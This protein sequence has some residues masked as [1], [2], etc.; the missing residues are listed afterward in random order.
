MYKIH[1]GFF[2]SCHMGLAISTNITSL[3]K[4][5]PTV[6]GALCWVL[7]FFFSCSGHDQQIAQLNGYAIVPKPERGEAVAT[8]AGGCFWAMQESLL[9]LKGVRMVLSGYAGGHTENPSYAAVLGKNTGHAE[10]VQV[11]YDPSV[12]SFRQL[13]TAF[14][15]AHDPTQLN[16]QGPDVGSDYRSIA[17]YRNKEELKTI[18]EVIKSIRHSDYPKAAIVTEREPFTVFYPAEMEHQD[19]YKRNTWDPYI[20][21]ISRPKVVHVREKLPGLIKAAYL[22]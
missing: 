5:R 7:L 15:Y 3:P 14:F 17:F 9:Q 13:S 11:Y 8:F 6:I 12:L 4:K 22:K 18:G 1:G 16:R 21:R 10:A 20:R 2:V 19:Y